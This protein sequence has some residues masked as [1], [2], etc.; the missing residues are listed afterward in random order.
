MY[1]QKIR[2]ENTGPIDQLQQELQF[3][4]NGFPKPFIL[5]GANGSGKSILL[6]YIVSAMINA[7][8]TVFDDSDMEKRK[9]Y[10]LRSPSYITYGRFYA[11]SCLEFTQGFFE[12]EITLIYFKEEFEAS[13]DVPLNF[14]HWDKFPKN[15]NSF[16]R[17]NFH[18]HISKLNTALI[19]PLLY[20]PP[21]RF[22]DPA[23]MNEQNL[24]YTVEYFRHTEIKGISHRP[25]IQYSPMKDNQN[26][27]LDLIYDSYVLG[28]VDI[29]S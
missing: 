14:K 3:H 16:I 5:V 11:L 6:A 23:W 12:D 20:F 13:Y 8:G 26:W 18:E 27:L 7:H 9:V 22:E 1:L 25:V 4:D 19:G 2:I 15:E 10:K 17:S 24:K 29:Y 28:P 21:N